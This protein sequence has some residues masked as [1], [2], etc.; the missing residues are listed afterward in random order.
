MNHNTIRLLST[1]KTGEPRAQYHLALGRRIRSTRLFER[2]PAMVK[3]IMTANAATYAAGKGSKWAHLNGGAPYLDSLAIMSRGSDEPKTKQRLL[4]LWKLSERPNSKAQGLWKLMDSAE[5]WIAAYKKLAANDGSMTK[6]GAEGTIDGTSL[7]GLMALKDMVISGKYKVGISRRV[8]IPKPKG[9]QRP[10]GIPEFRDRVIQEVIKTILECV[11]EP[12]FLESS[13]GFRPKRSQHTCLRQVRRDFGG[14]T[15]IIEGDIS[16]C[17]DTIDHVVAIECIHRHVDDAKFSRFILQGMKSKVLTPSGKMEQQ[18][19]GTPQGGVCSPLLSNIVLHQLDRFVAR[20]KKKVDLGIQRKR[21]PKYVSAINAATYGARTG[22]KTPLE[23]QRIRRKA[24]TIGSSLRDDSEFRRLNYVRYADDFLVGVTG[25]RD[26]A[27]RIKKALTDFLRRKLRLEVNQD[28]T[29]ISHVKTQSV[30]FLGYKIVRGPK[31]TMTHKRHYGKDTRRISRQRDGGIQL[32]VDIEKVIAGLE[33]KGYCKGYNPI[34][35]FRYYHQTQYHAVSTANS[36]I[37]GLGQ[38]YKLSEGRRISINLV[39]YIIRYSLAK[40]LSAK[41]KL[42]SSAKVFKI[43]GKDLS[44]PIK[45]QEKFIH[46]KKDNTDPKIVKSQAIANDRTSIGIL[47]T[48]YKDIPRPDTAPLARGWDPWKGRE[49][50]IPWPISRWSGFSIRGQS[51]LQS[52]CVMCEST[53]DIE[54]HHVRALK[55][56]KGKTPVEAAMM[57]ANRKQ[58]PLC[59]ICHLQTHGQSSHR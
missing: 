21:N 12:R 59:R 49:S 30:R 54:M 6:G 57:A 31:Y 45:G 3:R 38:Y 25:P 32:L 35:N 39:S 34:P 51:A 53:V 4:A 17:F 58:I 47:Y 43:A 2:K 23:V 18:T 8:Y 7:K 10:L 16:K 14:C 55:H 40:M 5:L 37:R 52:K 26:L 19:I 22:T 29:L 28:K 44:R 15:W 9:G 24:R 1:G 48:R 46:I 50:A 36:I 41:Y 33:F 27:V 11:F 42:H 20:L 56:I 13:H